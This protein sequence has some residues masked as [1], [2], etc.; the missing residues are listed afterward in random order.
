MGVIIQKG[1]K[2]L[3]NFEDFKRFISDKIMQ[4]CKERTKFKVYDFAECDLPNYNVTVKMGEESNIVDCMYD[5]VQGW[6]GIQ[7][8][9]SPFDNNSCERQFISDYYGGGFFDCANVYTED[10]QYEDIRK[11][12]NSLVR[13]KNFTAGTVIIWEEI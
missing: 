3:G 7:E 13:N 10:L 4:S 2:Y 12:V 9:K 11:A 1:N 8:L 6:Y 5:N